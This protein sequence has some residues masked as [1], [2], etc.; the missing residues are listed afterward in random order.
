ME[1]SG[2]VTADCTPFKDDGS[3]DER[4]FSAHLD[5][6]A[7]NGC[8][9]ILVSGTTGEFFSLLP[10]ERRRLLERARREFRGTVL[11]HATADS[12]AL[13]IEESRW[14][15]GAGADGIAALPPY[16]FADVSPQGLIRYFTALGNAIKI[17]LILYN[18]PRHA[19][20][21]ITPEVLEAAPHYA[22]KDS[23]RTLSL[24]PHTP[25]YFIGGDPMIVKTHEA[26]GRGFIS[27]LSNAFP[28]LYS[29]MGRAFQEGDRA[30]MD[31]FQP[32][33]QAA[34]ELFSGPTLHSKIKYAVSR[35]VAGFGHTVR[36]PLDSLSAAERANIDEFRGSFS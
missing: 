21:A 4:A 31:E 35:Q 10:R 28:A 24:L 26:G 33:I 5:F 36:P 30:R 16:Y 27:G 29:A 34:S 32:R 15:E 11:F 12:L 6:L 3:L 14:A 2:L 20:L 8:D 9:A 18:F 17:P 19:K 13:T 1:L 25:R 23:S 7:R 22:L